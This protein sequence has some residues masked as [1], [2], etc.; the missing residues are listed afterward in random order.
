MDEGD[1]DTVFVELA[2]IPRVLDELGLPPIAYPIRAEAM[3]E[4]LGNQNGILP[5][6][7]MLN[8]L[9]VKSREAGEEWQSLEPAMERLTQLLSPNGAQSN[10]SLSG[11]NWWLEI[12]KVDL[13]AEI[14][15][16]QRGELLI[17]A[18]NRRED[19]R[20]R[21]ST[22]R[23]LDAKSVDFL[24]GMSLNPHPVH[25]VAMRENN[26]EYALDQSAGS[27]HWYS[28]ERK[29]AYLSYWQTGIGINYDGEHSEN[30]FS[31]RTLAPRPFSFC[32][33]EI[34]VREKFDP[35]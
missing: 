3:T 5:F 16:I 29:E 27:R 25:G 28:Y 17:A 9:Q 10:I 34:M 1:I 30:W 7:E 11:Q 15:T 19:G 13:E 24:R 2:L 33:T 23:P 6:D 31:M 14:I 20:L 12:G 26:W 35:A 8:G 22:Y 18:I 32:E 21:V 4:A